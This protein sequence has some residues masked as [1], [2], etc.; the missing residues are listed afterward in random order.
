MSQCENCSNYYF[1][2]ESEEYC[3]DINLDEDEMV[4]FLGKNTKGCPYYRFYDEYKI[5]GTAFCSSFTSKN[6]LE[7]CITINI[8][9]TIEFLSLGF[10]GVLPF[11]K[12]GKM[13]KTCLQSIGGG[14]GY[15]RQQ[16]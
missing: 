11:G 12:F 8:P 14:T 13:V 2:D 15:Q 5:K 9:E 1:D 7:N 16:G 6:E 3:C 4:N 10:E